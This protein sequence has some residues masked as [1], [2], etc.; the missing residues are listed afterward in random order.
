M[1]HFA[2]SDKVGLGLDGIMKIARMGWT[3]FSG[4]WP[5]TI[6]MHVMARD[7]MSACPLY[8]TCVRD[9]VRWAHEEIGNR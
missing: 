9:A 7:Q 8:G 5:S 1:D 3:L 6:S 2:G 4:G